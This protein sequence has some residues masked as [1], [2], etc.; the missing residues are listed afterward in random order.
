MKNV[1]EI[2]KT[3]ML[4]IG[5]TQQGD[6]IRVSTQATYAVFDDADIARANI[7]SDPIFSLHEVRVYETAE[8]FTKYHRTEL[9][10]SALEKMTADERS[11]LGLDQVG[12][13]DDVDVPGV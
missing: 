9:R 5:S 1:Y 7:P 6:P 10:R 11:A 4:E 3:Q 13:E 8:E 2:R 12:P